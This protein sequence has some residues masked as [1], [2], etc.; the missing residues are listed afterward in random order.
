MPSRA[1]VWG[2]GGVPH[3]PEFDKIVGSVKVQG[4]WHLGVVGV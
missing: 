4:R 2:D 3:P 1:L